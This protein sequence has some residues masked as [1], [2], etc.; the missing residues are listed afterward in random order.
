[1]RPFLAF[2]VSLEDSAL[3]LSVS[4]S[5]YALFGFIIPSYYRSNPFY[6]QKATPCMF[7][8]FRQ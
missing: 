5:R 1:M 4:F 3:I 2:V 6:N 8:Y 7:T